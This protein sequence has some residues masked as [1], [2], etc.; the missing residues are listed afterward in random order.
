[1]ITKVYFRRN[2]KLALFQR[3]ILSM[4][5]LNIYKSAVGFIIASGVLFSGLAFTFDYRKAG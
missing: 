4:K 5:G 2:L 1:M 3:L